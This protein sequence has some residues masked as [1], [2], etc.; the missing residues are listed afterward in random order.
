VG[1]CC[2]SWR[3]GS[4]Q[5]HEHQGVRAAPAGDGVPARGCAVADDRPVGELGPVGV[6][7]G[8]VVEGLVVVPIA[9]D[10]VD[11]RV[12]E[13]EVALGV[14]VGEGD[15]PGPQGSARA[16]AGVPADRV[17]PPALLVTTGNPVWGLA[18]AAK[19]G[20]PRLAP[21]PATPFW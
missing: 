15:D 13:A 6:P 4:E 11:G 1:D 8:D 14:L 9:G 12:D 19:S 17:T 21:M 3:L 2:R 16:R 20:T 10:P 5:G 18:S 7:G